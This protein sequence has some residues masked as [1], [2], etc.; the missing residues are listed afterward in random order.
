MQGGLH[1][2]RNWFVACEIMIAKSLVNLY[3][4]TVMNKTFGLGTWN[5]PAGTDAVLYV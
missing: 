4:L 1:N 2:K 5:F 3:L